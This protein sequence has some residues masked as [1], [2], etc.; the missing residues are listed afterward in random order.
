M[1]TVRP[2]RSVSHVA[3]RWF[4]VVLIIT[5]ALGACGGSG[6]GASGAPLPTA[7]IAPTTIV[8]RSA[9]DPGDV[10]QV[11]AELQTVKDLSDKISD[12]SD[13]IL[14]AVGSG[15]GG[16]PEEVVA[17][18][19][20]LAT[21]IESDLPALLA[22]YDRAAAAAPAHI[23]TEIRVVADGTAVLTPPLAEAFRQADSIEDLAELE[24]VFGTL[25]LQEAATSAGISSLRLDNF[26]NPNC[27][28]QFSNA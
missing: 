4:P 23:A 24:N 11:C 8:A 21:E 28:F 18:F 13:A 15:E 12:G 6:D 3:A 19:G 7:S 2:A 17:S 16:T 5:V 1:C 25:E 22:A 20:A 10:E 27:G 14:I 26:T 9:D